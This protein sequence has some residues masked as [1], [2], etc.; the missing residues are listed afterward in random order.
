M[1][2]ASNDSAT[3]QSAGIAI[4]AEEIAEKGITASEE[5]GRAHV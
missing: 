1:S 5:I 4:T 2:F 3:K